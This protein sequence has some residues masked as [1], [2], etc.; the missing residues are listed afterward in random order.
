MDSRSTFRPRSA[1]VI[2]QGETQKGKPTGAARVKQVGGG[3]W[4]I[5]IPVNAETRIRARAQA[6]AKWPSPR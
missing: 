5:R 1:A 4:Q 6:E 3:S 2:S